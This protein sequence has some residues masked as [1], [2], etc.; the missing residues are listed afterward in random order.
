[1]R[2]YDLVWSDAEIALLEKTVGLTNDQSLQILVNNGFTDKNI[3]GVKRKRSKMGITN[4]NK[5]SA[6]D[7][8]LLEQNYQNMTDEELA[9]TFFPNRHWHGVA[10]R[11]LKLGLT[12]TTQ[13]KPEDIEIV[14]QNYYK[15]V[16][17]CMDLLPQYDREAIKWLANSL[18]LYVNPTTIGRKYFHNDNYFTELT[19]ENCYVA[20]FIAADGSLRS[21]GKVLSI[22]LHQQDKVILERFKQFFDYTGNIVD[23]ERIDKRTNTVRKNST[24]VVNGVHQW[25]TDLAKHFNITP[26]KTKTLQAPNLSSMDHKIAF[27]AGYIDGDGCIMWSGGKFYLDILGTESVIT[28]IKEVFDTIVPI[29]EN[30]I[31]RGSMLDLSKY[32][33]RYSFSL[34]KYRISGKRAIAIC[35]YIKQYDLPFLERKWSKVPQAEAP[36][37]A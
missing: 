30:G 8:A 27:I 4:N 12:K 6:E 35:Q 16:P 32:N 21:R 14:K 2:G 20:G 22:I 28:F 29:P 17:H 24:L 18:G 25:Y 36:I 3:S 26:A 11:R 31:G 13:W 9:A 19:M 7:I 37:A 10:A 23:A 5:W 33:N 1:M 15:G 34:N